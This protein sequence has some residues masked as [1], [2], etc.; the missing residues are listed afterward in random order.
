MLQVL[1]EL[2]KVLGEPCFPYFDMVAGTSTGGIIVAGLAQGL[3]FHLQTSIIGYYYLYFSLSNSSLII[4]VIHHFVY[5]INNPFA[6]SA[7][8]MVFFT[9]ILGRSLRECQKIYLRLK[10]LIFD[11]WTRPYNTAQLELFM[12]N[13]LG[14]Q[15]TL[16]DIR[17]PRLNRW[18]IYNLWFSQIFF[19]FIRNSI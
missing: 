10:D 12:Q 11:S 8:K 13:E 9:A 19:I 6:W 16:A 3:L 4:S 2:E 18:T 1:I 15:T 7:K 17:W 5:Y 14:T